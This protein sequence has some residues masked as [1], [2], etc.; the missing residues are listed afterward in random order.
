MGDNMKNKIN[1]LLTAVGC[2]GGPSII[3]SLKED[4]RIRIIGTDMRDNVPGK[5]LVDSF[6]IVPP[7]R[8]EFY[9]N[10]MLDI[11]KKEKINAILPL[12]TFELGSL[13]ENIS[14]FE[15]YGCRICISDK[16][17]IDISNNKFKLYNKFRDKGFIPK[18]F[19]PCSIDDLKDKMKLLG[20]PNKRVVI[21]PFIS[22]G[23]IGL[24]VID[25]EINL[26]DQYIN[27]KPS[28]IFIPEKMLDFIF[29]KHHVKDIL[30]SEYL[31]GKEIGVDLILD[32]ETNKVIKGI[33]RNNGNVLFSEVSNAF[34]MED[35]ELLSIATNIAEEI[36]LS[37]VINLDFKCDSYGEPKLLEI[38]PRMPA[39]SY[40]ATASGLNLPLLSI[41]L[42]MN[43]D[44]VFK[45]L[46]E[47]LKLSSYRGFMI[48]DNRGNNLRQS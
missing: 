23:S 3:K 36:G 11:V 10:E 22:H 33:V 12:A 8:S 30:I 24:R 18:Y 41:Y 43:I 19:A 40:L 6:Y 9:I 28:S 16:K 21:K 34:I 42:A 17:A 4:P 48:T 39:T 46:K 1:V 37:Y 44:F 26:Y 13:S 25:N 31:P 2:P 32:P 14:L 38:N 45:P 35:N 5:F 47:G 20:F 29:E 15:E 27:Y 7:G